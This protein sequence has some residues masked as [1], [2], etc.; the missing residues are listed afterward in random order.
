[1]ISAVAVH[2]EGIHLGKISSISKSHLF[3]AFPVCHEAGIRN[4]G[5]SVS[6]SAELI[7]SAVKIQNEKVSI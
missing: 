2:S 7:L 5:T 3:F 6:I 4:I 1:M